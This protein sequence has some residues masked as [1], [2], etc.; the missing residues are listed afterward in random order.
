MTWSK[1]GMQI[2]GVDTRGPVSQGKPGDDHKTFVLSGWGFDTDGSH[3]VFIHASTDGT[4]QQQ[5]IIP[6]VN[7][8]EVTVLADEQRLSVKVSLNECRAGKYH[9]IGWSPIEDKKNLFNN[10]TVLENAFELK[11]IA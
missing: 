7:S 8:G 1:S 10:A 9:L 2:F 6:C 4:L 11:K 5:Q 3:F